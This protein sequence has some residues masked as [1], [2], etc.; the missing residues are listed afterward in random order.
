MAL[1]P[2]QIREM[3]ASHSSQY[4]RP[5]EGNGY[6]RARA[7][8][9]MRSR[10]LPTHVDSPLDS[11]PDSATQSKLPVHHKERPQP[12]PAAKESSEAVQKTTHGAPVADAD[13][14]GSEPLRGREWVHN[15]GYG[16]EG[17]RP[18]TSSDQREESEHRVHLRT[19]WSE[20]SLDTRSPEGGKA[21]PTRPFSGESPRV[22][23]SK[24][25]EK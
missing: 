23:P 13:Q 10:M 22:S 12:V 17:G 4:I 18:R 25:R 9:P 7:H 3:G 1:R 6:R 8:Q 15:S 5:T 20:L 14:A 11:P 16:G 2:G 24:D 19:D 21:Q